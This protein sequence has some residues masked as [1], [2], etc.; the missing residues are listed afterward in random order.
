VHRQE[1]RNLGEFQTQRDKWLDV[2]WAEE[3]NADFTTEIRVEVGNRRGA[4]ATVAAAIS[5]QGCNIENVQSRER[6]GMT[7]ALEF[8]ISVKGR[9]HLARVMRRLRQIPLVMRINRVSH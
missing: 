4:L 3:G 5:E 7:S 9:A 6:D 1:C 2:E 8:L